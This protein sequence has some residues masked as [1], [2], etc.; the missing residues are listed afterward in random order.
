LGFVTT[1]RLAIL[2]NSGSG[3]ST[4]ARWIAGYTGVPLLDLDTIYWE[5]GLIAVAR[6]PEATNSD[7]HAFCT[8][9]SHWVIEG[10]YAAL[11]NEALQYSPLLIFLKPGKAQ[12]LANCRAR[13]WESHKYSSRE[14]Q[15]KH[16]EFLLTWV[17]EYYTRE[18]DMSLAGHEACFSAYRGRKVA[19]S[20]QPQF[21]PPSSEVLAW[22]T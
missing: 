1:V 7:L 2:G 18:G 9:N 5:P 10:C 13:P 16:L 8:K 11:M 3:K 21:D 17:G 20:V 19:V 22:L 12:C 14:E 4:L 6:S 15:D